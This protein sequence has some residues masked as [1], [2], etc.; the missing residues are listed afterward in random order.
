MKVLIP[1]Q[2]MLSEQIEDPDPKGVMP[3][4]PQAFPLLPGI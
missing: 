1:A 4:S 2:G 3:V